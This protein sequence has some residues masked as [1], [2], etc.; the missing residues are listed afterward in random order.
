MFA[1]PTGLRDIDFSMYFIVYTRGRQI[2]QLFGV[3][4]ELH[5][6]W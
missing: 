2:S 1:P 5:Y 4:G 6:T 3:F